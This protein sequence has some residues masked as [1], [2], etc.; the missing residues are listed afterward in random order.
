MSSN[1]EILNMHQDD[2]EDIVLSED[3]KIEGIRML[4]RFMK[5]GLLEV[6]EDEDDSEE[7]VLV[8][9]ENRKPYCK[10]VCCS[11]TFALTKDD[12]QKGRIKW[13]SDRPYFIKKEKDGFCYHFDRTLL[14]CRVWKDRPCRCR[15]YDCSKDHNVWIDFEKKIINKGVFKHLSKNK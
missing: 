2:D 14:R 8:D 10:A 5:L 11:F 4:E 6:W 13:D 12:Q 3:A 9:C 1:K 7:T 15:K